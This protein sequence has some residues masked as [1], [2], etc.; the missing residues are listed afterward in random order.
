MQSDYSRYFSH[1]ALGV[2]KS[3][4]RELLKLTAK[5][6]IISF[7]GG[8]PDPGMFPVDW[9]REAAGAVLEKHAASALQYGKTE[10]V[11]PLRDQ[12][13]KYLG[14][15]GIPVNREQLM[16]ITASQQGLDLVTRLFIDPGD[17]ILCGAPTYIGALQAFNSQR[18]R[19]MGID[20]EDDGIDTVRL[21]ARIRELAAQNTRPKFIYLVPDFQNPAGV[22][23]S[24]SKRREIVD[25]AEEHDLLIIE[26]TPYRQLRFEGE[27]PPPLISLNNRRVLSLFTCSKILLPGFRL[28]WIA[29]PPQLIEKLV[30]LKQ[31]VDLCSPTFN[32]FILAELFEKGRIEKQIERI[33][34]AYREKRDLMLEMLQA[35]MPREKGVSWTRPE[36]GLF[37]WVSLPERVN[38]GELFQQAIEKKVAY[39]VGEA[40][41]PGGEK[42]NSMRLNFSFPTTEDIREGIQR[43][44]R[45]IRES[46]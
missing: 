36:G 8:L 27:A 5:P 21:A 25:L 18:P 7:A 38:T 15:Q 22:T 45:L 16:V 30:T 10:G 14:R 11:D 3:Q 28:G 26:D 13:L 34:Q 23:L 37:L 41:Y 31:S 9:I 12:L 1:N 46:L 35:H 42:K 19:V 24:E 20:L 33:R 32:Q 17:V 2:K 44:G 4:I 39:V 29:G 40:F 6:D 43:L